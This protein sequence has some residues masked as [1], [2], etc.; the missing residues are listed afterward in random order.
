[1][2]HG[3]H[4]VLICAAIFAI[5]VAVGIFSSNSSSP[6]LKEARSVALV[7][8]TNN[9]F[10][11]MQVNMMFK[12]SQ[13]TMMLRD[14]DYLAGQKKHSLNLIDGAVNQLTEMRVRYKADTDEFDQMASSV[15]EQGN[16]LLGKT[17][18]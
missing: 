14:Q 13:L 2:F 10:R 7:T 12:E 8:L 4:K 11:E 18:Q 15:I 16:N 9:L 3:I 6:E 17:G 5:G 1:M